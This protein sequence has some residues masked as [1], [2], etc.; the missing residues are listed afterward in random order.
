MGSWHGGSGE[1]GGVGLMARKV[2]IDWRGVEEVATGAK[3]K[4]LVKEAAEAVAENARGAAVRVV[5]VPG[6]EPLPVKVYG[7]DET[8]GIEYA[9]RAVARVVLAHAAGLAAQAKHGL[10]SKAASEAGLRL[11]KR[12]RRS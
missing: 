5:G 3:M 9:D 8:Q 2:E 1:A 12:A 7:P 6:K 11:S 10:L 4:A